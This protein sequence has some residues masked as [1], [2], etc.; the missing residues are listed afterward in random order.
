M[1]RYRKAEYYDKAFQLEK[2]NCHYSDTVYYEMWKKVISYIDHSDVI[3]E[4]GCGT[5]Q[6][7]E[8]L[9]THLDYH[10]YIGIDFSKVAIQKAIER[11]GQRFFLHD[12][13]KSFD[14]N[15]NT[16]ICLETLEH[17]DNDIIVLKNLKSGTKFIGSVPIGNDPAHV[18]V[19]LTPESII[20]RYGT[21][22]DIEEIIL[23]DD[24]KKHL[25]KAT[26]K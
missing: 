18:R 14:S 12:A 4:I 11:N 2:Y 23:F 19:F 22:L 1:G 21:L 10:S 26:V 20:E 5:G 13:R 15:Y 3:L 8:M 9:F 6:F 16:V 17:I 25:F 7:A 24:I